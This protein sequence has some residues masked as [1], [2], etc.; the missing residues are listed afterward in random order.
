MTDLKTLLAQAQ[1]PEQSVSLCLRGDLFAERERVAREIAN[2]ATD[3]FGDTGVLELRHRLEQITEAM[4]DSTHTFTFVALPR[5]DFRSLRD[6]WPT[7][8]GAPMPQGFV[9][10]LVAASLTSPDLTTAEVTELLATLSEG[11]ASVLEDAAW[12]VNQD[13]DAVPLPPSG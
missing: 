12:A 11:Q 2:Y 1:R 4:H 8:P 9:D 6:S 5:N 10:T 3:T 7:E 13:S